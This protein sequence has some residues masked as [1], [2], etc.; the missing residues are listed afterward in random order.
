MVGG[1]MNVLSGATLFCKMT[2]ASKIFMIRVH[3]NALCRFVFIF[4]TNLGTHMRHL[5]VII[6]FGRNNQ[7]ENTEK[8]Y[9]LL[10]Y[11]P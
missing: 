8:M 3:W 6:L 4:N 11:F 7:H 1:M 2:H 9:V 5:M 10:H